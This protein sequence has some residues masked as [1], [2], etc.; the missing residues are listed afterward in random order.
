MLGGIKMAM[1]PKNKNSTRYFSTKQEIYIG[2]LVGGRV[3]AGSGNTGFN[4]GD[5]VTDSWL[6]EAKTSMT[7][8]NSFSIKKEWIT[9]NELERMEMHKPYSAIVFQFEPDGTNYFVIDE[10][11]FKKLL[12][13]FENE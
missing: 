10:K 3:Q 13:K 6:Y 2:N 9:K 5:I 7:P 8:K 11:T 4:K 1:V 12:D